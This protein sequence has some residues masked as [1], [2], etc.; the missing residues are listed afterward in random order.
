MN[1][2]GAVGAIW[3][4]L[5]VVLAAG[6]ASQRPVVYPNAHY[7]SVGKKAAEE[8]IDWCVEYAATHGAETDHAEKA[9]G[10]A[11]KGAAVGGVGGAVAGGV[12]GDIGTGAAA[13][14]AGGAA[15]G[16]TKSIFDSGKPDE[17][18]R[19]FVERCL[20]D[21]GYQPVGWR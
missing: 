6:C 3:M 11:A 20:R 21:L 18:E 14:V 5:L 12:A 2:K 19:R 15:A 1:T 10:K 7:R 13:G 8:D 17:V 9:A 4:G 16:L